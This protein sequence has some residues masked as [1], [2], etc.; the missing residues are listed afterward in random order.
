MSS[1]QEVTLTRQHQ[2]TIPKAI[3]ASLH[4]EGGDRFEMV[5]VSGN[6]LLLKQ[7]KLIDVDDPAYQLGQEI[8]EA[9][10]QIERGEVVEWS[11]VKRRHDL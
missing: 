11:D 2:I 6:K 7:K 8:L 9:E 3:C 5:I 4:L 10:R 1:M